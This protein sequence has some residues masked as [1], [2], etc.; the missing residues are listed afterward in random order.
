M[1]GKALRGTT[2][3]TY[4]DHKERM[5][6]YQRKKRSG[7]PTSLV[8]PVTMMN[9]KE[10][11]LELG[12]TTHIMRKIVECKRS[13]FP[14]PIVGVEERKVKY[15]W[16]KE[17]ADWAPYIMALKTYNNPKPKPEPLSTIDTSSEYFKWFRQY[18]PEPHH[19]AYRKFLE[20]YKRGNN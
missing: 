5:R 6:E 15:Y 10:I 11:Q 20:R 2:P 14:D 18:K 8:D 1:T 16:R 13:K 7:V 9:K 3:V 17:I 12:V 19:I 4:E